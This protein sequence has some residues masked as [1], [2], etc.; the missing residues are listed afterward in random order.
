VGG[1]NENVVLDAEPRKNSLFGRVLSLTKLDNVSATAPSNL[2]VKPT[3]SY[4][5]GQLV[6]LG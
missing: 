6:V 3:S 2:V 1:Q 5:F 4:G